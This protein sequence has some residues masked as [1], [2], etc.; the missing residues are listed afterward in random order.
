MAAETVRVLKTGGLVFATFHARRPATPEGPL[1]HKIV[2]ETHILSE[3]CASRPLQ[4]YLYQNREIERLFMGLKIVELYFLKQGVRE[5]LLEK[6]AGGA[7]VTVP[8]A[9]PRTGGRFRIE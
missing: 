1:R 8:A 9:T 7:G 3:P 6:R 4:R 2:D 5:M